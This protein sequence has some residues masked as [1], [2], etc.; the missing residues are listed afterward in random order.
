MKLFGY[1]RSSATFRVRIAL[2][3]KNLKYDYE[4][5]NLLKNEQNS[6]AHLA[7][8]PLGLVPALQTDDGAVLTQ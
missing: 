4:P 3:L 1:W 2:A 5:V 7:R 6:P 8:N